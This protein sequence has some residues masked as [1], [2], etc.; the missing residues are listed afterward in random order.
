M[1]KRTLK[2]RSMTDI[3]KFAKLS[4][5]GY[6]MNT[7]KLTLTGKFSDE[8]VKEASMNFHAE[9][10]ETSDRVYSYQ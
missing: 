6:L 8:E 2:F 10:I 4:K 5:V 7:T 1:E 3:A 9:E